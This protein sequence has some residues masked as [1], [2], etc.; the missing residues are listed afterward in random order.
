VEANADSRPLVLNI[1]QKPFKN[2][3]HLKAL[4]WALKD[5][6]NAGQVEDM[7]MTQFLKLTLGHIKKP[8][9]LETVLSMLL[10]VFNYFAALKRSAITDQFTTFQNA[11]K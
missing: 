7:A 5:L 9:L 4:L 11:A 3:V 6:V 2:M 10:F 1:L 8:P